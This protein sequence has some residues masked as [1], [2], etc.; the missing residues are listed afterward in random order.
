MI[1][2]CQI[3]NKEFESKRIDAL[4]C[5][6]KCRKNKERGVTGKDFVTD[7]QMKIGTDKVSKTG[8][9]YDYTELSPSGAKKVPC[10]GCG[11]PVWEYTNPC[12]NCTI[13]GTETNME[14]TVR[15]GKEATD[16]LNSHTLEEL[17]KKGIWIP[18][19]RMIQG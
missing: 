8:L 19:W 7:D 2:K 10:R 6:P 13:P 16:T 12:A 3:C 4:Y 5:S 15:M 14:E 1:K 17:K 9:N 18:S 11:E